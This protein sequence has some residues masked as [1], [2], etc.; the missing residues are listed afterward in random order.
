MLE[1][2]Y[3]GI[4]R[5]NISKF[6]YRKGKIYQGRKSKLGLQPDATLIDILFGTSIKHNLN[7]CNTILLVT[8]PTARMYQ[9]FTVFVD[10]D[11][12]RIIEERLDQPIDALE[13]STLRKLV[14]DVIKRSAFN[15]I[16][17]KW[18]RRKNNGVTI[19]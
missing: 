11:V 17:E 12:V 2:G 14:F 5:V 15:E 9:F 18:D 16:V 7:P 1:N 13:E 8:I 10:G 3:F 19:H 4:V 6:Y